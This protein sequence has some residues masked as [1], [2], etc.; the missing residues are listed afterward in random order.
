MS[1]ITMQLPIQD[2]EIAFVMATIENHGLDFF[3]KPTT[4]EVEISVAQKDTELLF[5]LPFLKR[6]KA[7]VAFSAFKKNQL[8]EIQRRE[9]QE[10]EDMITSSLLDELEE[11]GD[12]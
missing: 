3:G 8:L 12:L 7:M 9:I 6:A 5:S 11:N 4:D 1:K 10:I 2:I